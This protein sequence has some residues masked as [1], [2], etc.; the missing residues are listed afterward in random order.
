MRLS[1]III[2]SAVLCFPPPLFAGGCEA[3]SG[4]ATAA[5][6]ELYTSEGCSSCPPADRQLSTLRSVLDA[7]AIIVP[8][9]LHVTYWDQIGWKDG[10]AQGAFDAR[11]REL[12]EQ[13][14]Q[15]V[16]YTP[17]VFANGEELRNWG[18]ALPATVR[19]INARPAPVTITLRSTQAGAAL[20]LDAAVT[21]APAAAAGSLYLAVVE[22]GL[23][24]Q[25]LRGENRGALLHHDDLV[26]A[27]LGPFP[28]QNGRLRLRQQV[29]VPAAWR[30]EQLHTVA[31]VQ[32][33]S[34]ILQAVSTGRCLTAIPEKVL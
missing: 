2:S 26:R 10:F 14:R 31:F 17:Q 20:T 30:G 12:V 6:V 32:A 29:S 15:H 11:Q 7:N 25:V 28:L 27:W 1:T 4:T 33:G 24:T 5:L 18:V 19:R 21:S 23:A 34:T 22:S 9:A 16:V 13:S 8:L 3:K